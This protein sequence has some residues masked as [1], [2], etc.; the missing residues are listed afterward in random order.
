MKTTNCLMCTHASGMFTRGPAGTMMIHCKLLKE[1]IAERLDCKIGELMQLNT[2]NNGFHYR[3]NQGY[4][5]QC[6]IK[7]EY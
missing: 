7:L 5:H 4:C 2:C 1:T 3:D 6:G